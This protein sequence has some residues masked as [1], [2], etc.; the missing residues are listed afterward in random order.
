M[1]IRGYKN[2]CGATDTPVLDFWWH[3]LW[4][5]KP[6]WEALF[7][8]G[9]GICVTRSQLV[10]HLLSYWKPAWQLSHSLPH[11][12]KQVL[13]GLKQAWLI[14]TIIRPR[15]HNYCPTIFKLKFWP[16]HMYDLDLQ[17]KF[18]LKKYSLWMWRST[19]LVLGK[20]IGKSDRKIYLFQN[21]MHLLIS[22]DLY[23]I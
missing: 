12:C 17:I 9:G 21:E 4:V 19:Q 2:F 7:T 6:E 23:I 13:V 8:L 11:T 18:I 15:Y 16:I 14:I 3:L 1:D 20:Q 5:S 10:Q 22:I